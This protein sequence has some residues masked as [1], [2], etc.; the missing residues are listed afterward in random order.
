MQ[1]YSVYL[2]IDRQYAIAKDLPLPDRVKGTALFADISGF[3]P[4]TEALVRE[5]GPQRGAEELT[6]YLNKVYDTLIDCLHSYGGVVI[7]FA[8]DSVTCWFNS[9]DGLQAATCALE[10][11]TVMQ[12]FADIVVSAGRAGG[13]SVSLAVK[14]TIATGPARRFV[15]GDPEIQL[16]DVLAGSTLY[17]LAAADHCAEKNRVTLDSTSVRS[18]GERAVLQGSCKSP[19]GNELYGIL[20]EIRTSPARKSLG[21]L[22]DETFSEEKLAPWILPPVYQRLREGQG[23]FLAE[24]RPAIVFFLNFTGIDFDNDETAGEKLDV[25]VRWVQQELGRFE[26]YLLQLIVGD[27]G[28]YLYG[29]FG[30]PIAHEDDGV[31]AVSAALNLLHLPSHLEYIKDI[32]IGISQGRLRT[33]AYG[34]SQRRTYGVIGN[35]VNLAARLME[36]ATPGQIL[37][38][39]TVKQSA[40]QKFRWSSEE[41]L[42]QAKGKTGLIEVFCPLGLQPRRASRLRSADY[43]LPMV[44]RKKELDL[45]EQ[46]IEL[47][48]QGSGQLIG[49]TGEAGVGKSR[50]IY[51]VINK[52][53][54]AGFAYYGGECQS[55]TVESSYWPWQPVWRGLFNI[56]ST[57]SALDQVLLAAETLRTI[58]PSLLPR[59]PLLQTPLGIPI[60]ENVFSRK[61]DAKIRKTSLETLL[62]D[63]LRAFASRGPLLIVLEDCQWLDK[64]SHD[65]IE[66]IGHAI[67]DLPV[68]IIIAY[69]PLE[70]ERLK[71]ARVSK[72]SHFTLIDI[73]KFNPADT[74]QLI[75]LKLQQ[76]GI[77]QSKFP[78]T[79]TERIVA[80]AE[81][82]PFYVEELLNYIHDRGFDQVEQQENLTTLELPTSLHSLILSRVDQLTEK[83]QITLKV[84]S[85]I[86]RLFKA[87][88]LW[89]MY[90]ELGQPEQV[91]SDLE[92]LSHLHITAKS[93]TEPELTYFFQQLLTQQVAYENL[94]YATRAMLHQQLASF[95]ENNVS[96]N[97]PQYTDLLALHYLKGE[98]WPKALEYNLIAARRNQHEY[99]NEAAIAACLN[100][101]IAI[102]QMPKDVDVS[103]QHLECCNILGDVRTLVGQYDAAIESYEC[104]RKIIDALPAS[105]EKSA[106]QAHLCTQLSAVYERKSEFEQA[107]EWLETGLAAVRDQSYSLETSRIYVWGGGLYR[108][109]GK[110]KEAEEWCKR[111]L[112]IARQLPSREAKQVVAQAYYNLGT[113]YTRQG[114]SQ[115]GIEYCR[116]SLEIFE[117]IQDVSGQTRA[118]N[119]L[120]VIYQE[121]GDLSRSEQAYNRGLE[122]TQKIGDI[123]QAGF[124]A[125]NVGNIYLNQG[126][127]DKAAASFKRSHAIWKQLG[128]GWAAAVTLSNMAQV[129]IYQD[130]LGAAREKL[131]ES[132]QL[133]K[134]LNVEDFL[135]ELERR[136]SEYYLRVGDVSDGMAHIRQSL[137]IAVAQKNRLDE[138]LSYRTLG[139]ILRE[140][141]EFAPSRQALQ[142]SLEILAEVNNEYEE[143]RTRLVLGQVELESG[144]Q[145]LAKQEFARAKAIFEKLGTQIYAAQASALA[146]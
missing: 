124:F 71:V 120:G 3:T 90:P 32:K 2:P 22:P 132:E 63:C 15:V 45:A 109:Q 20:K 40:R 146:T 53:A 85:V 46:K 143:A 18:L 87:A 1:K 16:I 10:M 111:S 122:L 66:V 36:A 12:K 86:G 88:L 101:K 43:S 83:Q 127:W 95:L 48:L 128:A 5:F 37:T 145:E 54:E 115:K 21:N 91:T 135:S 29:T 139:E 76:F 141:R 100:A 96:E 27:K 106:Q 58:Q 110:Q 51:E 116:E 68:I 104:A 56:M 44:G 4:L 133:F 7:S 80:E 114:L 112:E 144:N 52:A 26:G 9:D 93:L 55:Y 79:L 14:I 25:Y 70:L 94:P 113:I 42:I 17:R 61:L 72:Q 67:T 31:R 119:N 78:L 38:N 92:K 41:R 81:G 73:E 11:Q 136:W 107:F 35:D 84:A 59:L 24:L 137:D 117:Q 33:G 102:E 82:N 138:G 34:G 103:E 126:E 30:A 97:I 89:G 19:E 134:D 99:A 62:V 74:S 50:L 23:E 118:Y 65:L 129:D 130:K 60:P 49:I 140:K 57:Q 77:D 64:L 28:N 123:Q 39:Q 75:A 69:R 98:N 6:R 131:S 121:M 108:R 8:G 125:N 47:A 105:T 13:L 142:T